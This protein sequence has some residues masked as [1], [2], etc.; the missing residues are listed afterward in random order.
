MRVTTFNLGSGPAAE[1]RQDLDRLAD[2]SDVL[3]LQEAGDRQPLLR[4]WASGRDWSLF[5][6]RVGGAAKVPILT[7]PGV[8]VLARD[9]VVAV[10]PTVVGEPG[11]GPARLQQKA[12]SRL[13]LSVDGQPVHV[14][15]THLIASATRR[16]PNQDARVAHYRRHIDALARVVDHLD[17][18]VVVTGD[19]NAPRG[20]ALLAPLRERLTQTT[21]E[22]TH[23]RRVIDLIWVRGTT[24]TDSDVSP[25]SSDHR[26]ATTIVAFVQRAPAATSTNTHPVLF[27]AAFGGDPPRLRQWVV[28]GL[29]PVTASDGAPGFLLAHLALWWHEQLEPVRE[30]PQAWIL[31]LTRGP[32]SDYSNHASGTAIDLNPRL[33]P[34]GS[35][36]SLS[37]D[38]SQVAR[39]KRHVR[40]YQGAVHWDGDAEF[41]NPTHAEIAVNRDGCDQVA[42]ALL[43]RR[44]SARLLAANPGAAEILA[45][46]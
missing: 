23:G 1:V 41:P 14:V 29:G 34:A 45:S 30:P 26:A 32:G 12:I 25:T 28:P 22:P 8:R 43:G 4:D 17:G 6:G 20:H 31:P 21:T 46:P 2:A 37:L 33:H 35:A 38:A 18:P 5:V 9:A 10:P 16:L 42:R 3:C 7:A 44:R 40:T 27:D 19:F 24:A 13:T 36:P 11:A 15:N 39:L